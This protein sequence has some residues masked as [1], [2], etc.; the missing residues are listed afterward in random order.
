MIRRRGASRRSNHVS[1]SQEE[2]TRTSSRWSIL[3]GVAILLASSAAQADTTITDAI[4]AGRAVIDLRA[5]YENVD[6]ASKTPMV[7]E[8]GMF[9]ARLGYETGAWNGLSLQGDFDQIWLIGGNY[10][11]TRN[12]KTTYP[13]IADPTMTALN[14]LQLTYAPDYDTKFVVGRQRILVG[15]MRFIGNSG[16]RQ[17]EQTFDALS[18]V[19]T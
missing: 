16:W 3:A 14:R 5:R 17:Q 2:R 13:I 7:G 9:R 4:A 8:A 19:N 11:S 12:G 1:C 15:N 6:D 18:A 10:N